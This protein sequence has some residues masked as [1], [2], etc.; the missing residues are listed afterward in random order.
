MTEYIERNK[1]L[2]K[3][4]PVEGCFSDMISAYDVA[5][6]PTADV[7]PVVHG[8]WIFKNGNC[9]CNVCRKGLSYDGNGVMLDLSHLPYCPHCGARMDGDG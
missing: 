8:K 5:S 2:A 9:G 4:A 1:V 3:A 6:I 7:A